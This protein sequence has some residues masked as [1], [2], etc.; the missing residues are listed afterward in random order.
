MVVSITMGSWLEVCFWQV[1]C[2]G[3]G[4]KPGWLVRLG[5][6]LPMRS[7][8]HKGWTK[9]DAPYIGPLVTPYLHHWREA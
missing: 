1:F 5:L 6:M 3:S 7:L 9:E 2:V 8:Q 4:E